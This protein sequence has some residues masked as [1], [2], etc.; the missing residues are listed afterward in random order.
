MTLACQD[1]QRWCRGGHAH[2]NR[3]RVEHDIVIYLGA[4]SSGRLKAPN[5]G[6]SGAYRRTRHQVSEMWWPSIRRTVSPGECDPGAHRQC[7]ATYRIRF[8]VFIPARR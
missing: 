2:M 3:I 5:E 6:R 7:V 4:E 8:D 1:P